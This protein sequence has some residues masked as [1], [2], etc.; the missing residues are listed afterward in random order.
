MSEI[1]DEIDEAHSADVAQIRGW[2]ANAATTAANDARWKYYH[3]AL[4]FWRWVPDSEHMI[5]RIRYAAALDK[6][7]LKEEE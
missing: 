4:R 7:E 6:V 3:A 2:A 1:T 5:A